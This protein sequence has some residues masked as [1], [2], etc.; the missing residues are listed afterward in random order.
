MIET[1]PWRVKKRVA[2]TVTTYSP[3]TGASGKTRNINAATDVTS[4][5]ADIGDGSYTNNSSITAASIG[6][7]HHVADARLS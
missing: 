2:P 3:A 7:W 5:V 4:S 6:N 1:V